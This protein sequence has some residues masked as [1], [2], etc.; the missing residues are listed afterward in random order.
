MTFISRGLGGRAGVVAALVL[1]TGYVLAASTVICIF[2]S[3]T[4][5]VLTRN[6]SVSVPWPVARCARHAS[7]PTAP[8]RAK[9]ALE[10]LDRAEAGL[11]RSHAAKA[12]GCAS[13]RFRPPRSPS[14]PTS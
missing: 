3:W 7:R 13:G 8:A 14:W 10:E 9:A 4:H 12:A 5:N 1:L 11:A 2:D 6:F